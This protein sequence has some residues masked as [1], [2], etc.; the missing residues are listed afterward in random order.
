MTRSIALRLLGLAL[1]NKPLQLGGRVSKDHSTVLVTVVPWD[2]HGK[3]SGCPP[4]SE[5]M[6]S[7]F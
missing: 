3:A 5:H 4:Q 6:L 1:H 2:F 7:K